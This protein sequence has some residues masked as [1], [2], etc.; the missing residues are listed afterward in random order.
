[1]AAAPVAAFAVDRESRCVA[2]AGGGLRLVALDESAPGTLLTEHWA[3]EA[4]LVSALERAL[5]GEA[6]SRTLETG[7]RAVDLW[8]TPR[9]EGG[10]TGVA[11]DAT[12]RLLAE[13]QV[14]W[15]STHDSLTGLPSRAL[16][17]DR[18]RMALARGQRQGRST[19][20][21][22]LDLD[23]L[24]RINQGLGYEVGDHV[25]MTLTE[26]MVA[27]VR[28][29]DTVGRFAGDTFV[30]VVEELPSVSAA[31]RLAER[32]RRE[33]AQPIAVGEQEVFLSASVG[34]AMTR[35][36]LI[37]AETLFA[38]A[39]AAMQRAK[40]GGHGIE[41]F[42]E[43]RREPARRRL[44][45]EQALYRAVERDEL[46]LFYQ[47][48][49]DLAT[50]RIRAIEALVRWE[51]P[52]RGLVPPGEFIPLA[53]ETGLVVAIGRWVLER[54]TRRAARTWPGY[55]S[56]CVNLSARQL[57][58]PDLA[59]SVGAVLTE[60]GLDPSRLCLELTESALMIDPAAAAATLQEL[61]DLGAQ[62]AVDDFGTGYSSLGYLKRFP[63]D[64]LKVDR[65]F[66]DGVTTDPNDRAITEAVIQLAH[67]L[68]L[69]AVGEGVETAAQLE[70]LRAL[71][72][73]RAQGFYFAR[74]IR[75]GDELDRLLEG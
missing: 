60:S 59:E 67:T 64:A 54:A 41:L 71:G 10:A 3:A 75:D 43:T 63:L 48:V 42:D 6:V 55:V 14:A 49:V 34:I 35:G 72:C 44:Q 53:E 46:C 40:L 1:M 69:T 33:I 11:V 38:D 17:A 70:V 37:D 16:L 15:Q 65:S 30:V 57:G 56:V 5:A 73:D 47:P 12:E 23:R 58:Q 52:E 45:T 19:A 13:H 31:L 66:V 50:D 20:M 68:G 61:K 74:P 9:P 24:A 51:H 36:L 25:L 2:V 39:E 21:L 8:L 29:A 26:R 18:V 32:I 4:G 28:P 22:F 27:T 7:G 62:L